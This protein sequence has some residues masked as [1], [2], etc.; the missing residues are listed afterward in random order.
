M[1]DEPR[2]PIVAVPTPAQQRVHICRTPEAGD[3]LDH[4][5]QSPCDVGR[6]TAAIDR[7]A[8]GLFVSVLD[9]LSG[10]GAGRPVPVV[11][12]RG[13][14][15]MLDA[16]RA[17]VGYGPWGFVL[18]HAHGRRKGV[19][20]Q[21]VDI[22][23]A[24]PGVPYLLVDPIVNTGETVACAMEVL[25]Q[26]DAVAQSP[27]LVKLVCVFLTRRGEEHIHGHYPELEIFTAWDSLMVEPNGWV[28]GV[29][30]DA[31]DLAMGGHGDRRLQQTVG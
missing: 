31:G 21:R 10:M 11:I 26:I 27:G 29:R 18:P 20:A 7:V 14:L 28:A 6:V 17:V 3:L 1:A 13:G 24:A 22:P 4:A 15:L 25:G 2:A 9:M 16:C 23:I 12:L 19:S 8:T 30:F 5:R